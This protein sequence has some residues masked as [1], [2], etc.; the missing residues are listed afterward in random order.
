MVSGG[1]HLPLGY[2]HKSLLKIADAKIHDRFLKNNVSFTFG[3]PPDATKLYKSTFRPV[4]PYKNMKKV[5]LTPDISG[6]LAN[7]NALRAAFVKHHYNTSTD[8][9]DYSVISFAGANH[10]STLATLSLSTSPQKANLPMKENWTILDFPDNKSD[11]SR[12]LENY[13]H[14][15]RKGDGK[16]AAVIVSPLQSLTYQ[17]ASGDFYKNLRNIAAEHGI[18]F[19]VDETFTGCGASGTYWA[20][21]QWKLDHQPDLVTFGRRTQASGFYAT[22][23]FLPKEAGW[24]FFNRQTADGT[25]MIQYQTIQKTIKSEGLVEKTK[26]MGE[27]LQESLKSV[28]GISNV[29]G[30]GTMVAFDTPNIDANLDLI[31]KLKLNGVNVSASGAKTIALRPALIFSEKHLNEFVATLRKSLR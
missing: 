19:I 16:V 30:L 20:H 3:P 22:R 6:E 23:D 28:S 1:G 14:A 8:A 4:S 10:G 2:N 17:N 15:I 18:T 12:V 27:K 25:R 11:E 5:H 31:H 9:S 7:E 26:T 24:Q 29:R 13:E 21:E